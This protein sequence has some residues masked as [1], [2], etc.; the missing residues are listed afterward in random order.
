MSVAH[1]G[2]QVEKDGI[3]KAALPSSSNGSVGATSDSASGAG[4][5]LLQLGENRPQISVEAVAEPSKYPTTIEIGQNS[6][7]PHPGEIGL[8]PEMIALTGSIPSGQVFGRAIVPRAFNGG[9]LPETAQA[10]SS[11]PVQQQAES[12]KKVQ[13]LSGKLQNDIATFVRTKNKNKRV[14]WKVEDKKLALEVLNECGGNISMCLRTLHAS[15]PIFQTISHKMLRTWKNIMASEE[16]FGRRGRKASREFETDLL[17]RLGY[18]A[19]SRQDGEAAAPSSNA[20]EPDT[21]LTYNVVIGT[22]EELR[23]TSQWA[24]DKRV[25]NLKLSHHWVQNF[26]DR[27]RLRRRKTPEKSPPGEEIVAPMVQGIQQAAKPCENADRNGQ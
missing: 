18:V 17:S 8:T 9:V 12:V 3:E 2:P 22:A 25:Q 5:A 6:I 1:A 19:L 24:D 15:S 10:P 21:S 7:A 27:F 14:S 23:K 4:L 26:L 20:A 13:A 16:G 11:Q